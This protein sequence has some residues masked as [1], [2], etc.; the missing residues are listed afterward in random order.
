V[1]RAREADFGTAESVRH[2]AH[3]MRQERD[4]IRARAAEIGAEARLLFLDLPTIRRQ[5]IGSTRNGA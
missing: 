1:A 2:P 3:L 4:E 5:C